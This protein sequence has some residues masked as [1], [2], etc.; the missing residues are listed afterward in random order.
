M[1]TVIASIVIAGLAA[2]AAAQQKTEAVPP[3][4]YDAALAQKLGAD[5]YGMKRYVLVILK[6]GPKTD[7]PAPE[8]QKAF[9]GH[10]ANIQ[11]L[12]KE[13]KLALAGPMMK[14]DKGYQGI[15]I[16][17]VPT[18]KEAEELVATDPAVAGGFLSFEFFGWYGTAALPEVLPIHARI[19]KKSH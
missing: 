3:S 15:F 10:M 16:F 6:T 8:Q 2:T 4:G 1:R 17:N 7:A 18:I 14:N 9:A 11:R 12:A 5:E 13:N 19:E